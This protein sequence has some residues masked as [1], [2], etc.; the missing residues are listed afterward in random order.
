VQ[1]QKFLLDINN[2]LNM[3]QSLDQALHKSIKE[4][5]EEPLASQLKSFEQTN[6]L[7]LVSEFKNW[8]F[9]LEKIYDFEELGKAANL[10]K[11]YLNYSSN[12][13]QVFKDTTSHLE[14]NLQYNSELKNSKNLSFL[15]MDLMA[16]MYFGVLIFLLPQLK[17]YD[18]S[19]WLN[20]SE[21]HQIILITS[22][23]FW[24]LYLLVLWIQGRQEI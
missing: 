17:S 15:T 7:N 20:S 11:L 8:L 19:F 6:N 2:K 18:K 5:N 10:V 12:Y 4:F 24:F 1:L 3:G 21:Y 13:K 14:A 16:F 9:K 22:Y 23:C